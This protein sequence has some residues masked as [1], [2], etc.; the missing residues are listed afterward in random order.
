MHGDTPV[1]VS[2]SANLA[3]ELV[4]G[5]G[6]PLNATR[7]ESEAE[8]LTLFGFDNVAFVCID[9]QFKFNFQVTAD[10]SPPLS[11]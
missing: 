1:A 7:S 5:F 11:G 2:Q 10:A 3:F 8:K 6:R 4:Q 9:L